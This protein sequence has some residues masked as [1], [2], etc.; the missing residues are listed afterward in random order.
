MKLSSLILVIGLPL[1]MSARD[2]AIGDNAA[3]IR[4]VM[5]AARG[6]Y[7]FAS[8]L[9]WTWAIALGYVASVLVHLAVNAHHFAANAP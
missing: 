9:R 5:G 8:H 6:Q 4:E 7:T 3:Q 1:T 2:V